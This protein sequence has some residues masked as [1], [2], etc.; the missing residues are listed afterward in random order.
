MRLRDDRRN[1]VVTGLFVMAMIGALVVW[2]AVLSGFTGAA[3][4]YTTRFASVMGLADGT[5]VLFEGYRVGVVDG[6][7]PTA[8]RDFRVSL[9]IDRDFPIPAD[10]V[11][12][13]S[14]SG[15]LA[16]VVLNIERGSS[17]EALSPG[18]EIR[19]EPPADVFA[20][21]GELADE[22][23]ALVRDEVGPLMSSL[24]ARAPSILESLD[25]FAAELDRAATELA[26]ILSEDSHDRIERILRNLDASS[27]GVRE[28]VGD[29]SGS[30]ERIESVLA[31]LDDLVAKGGP[32]LEAALADLRVSLEAL[33]RRS[34]AISHHLEAT[35][36]NFNE[37]SDEI[38]RDPSLLLRG[39]DG[40]E[41]AEGE[42]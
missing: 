16:A 23:S 25:H 39:R 8:E 35:T 13:L 38:R 29:L 31:T 34:D 18:D 19:S 15:L 20:A 1:Y 37:F 42:R 10:S 28:L 41:P 24:G 2:L 7:E 26:H 3:D 33:A 30:R 14:S 5:Q 6:I 12:R 21:V 4:R 9:S 11:V 27:G 36:R 32:D 22:L 40:E 17:S